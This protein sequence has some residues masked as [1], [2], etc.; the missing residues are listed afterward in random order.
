M[1]RFNQGLLVG[2][3][4]ITAVT[5]GREASADAPKPV[6]KPMTQAQVKLGH[7]V[8]ADGMHGFVLDRTGAKAK[9]QIDGEKDIWELTMEEDRTRGELR[10]YLFVS[11]DGARRL[12]ISTGGS[13]TYY[14]GADEHQ[15][16]LD[17]Q[18]KPLGAATKKGAPVRE[19]P[20]SE[21][22]ASELAPLTVRAKFKLTPNDASNLAKV[23]EAFEKADAAMFVRY[24]DPGKDGW[25]GR[26]VVTPSDVSGA[27]YGGNDYSTDEA[28]LKRH[29]KI[30]KH[31]GMIHGYS[32][33]ETPQGN[34]IKVSQK[35]SSD[36]KLADNTRQH[37]SPSSLQMCAST[38]RKLRT[39]TRYSKF[40]VFCIKA[41]LQANRQHACYQ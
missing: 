2:L 34:H 8:T 4:A 13:L 9:L 18:V 27:G 37:R 29:T 33:P 10:G 30:A 14:R 24:K 20:A 41:N 12:F 38:F 11:N 39:Y 23:T 1:S 32:S 31:G 25:V 40:A 28:E 36:A 16:T 17:K 35:D 19:V 22:L 21:K 6:A 7:F 15:V 26:M 3:V 5:G